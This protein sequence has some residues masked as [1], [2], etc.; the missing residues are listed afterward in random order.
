MERGR[1]YRRRSPLFS[2][3][4]AKGIPIHI[5]SG[6]QDGHGKNAVPLRQSLEAFNALAIANGQDGKSL[7]ETEVDAM[8]KGAKIPGSLAGE[9]QDD[10]ARQHKIFFRRSAGPVT[11]T[12]FDAGHT[13]D[14]RTGIRYFE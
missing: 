2:L 13:V 7:S 11:L 1:E 14:V 5:D 12:I 10:P 6:I 9:R 4:N 8:T 3:G